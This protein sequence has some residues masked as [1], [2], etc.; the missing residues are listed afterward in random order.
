MGGAY[1]L[2]LQWWTAQHYVALQEGRGVKYRASMS[3]T[4]CY[5]IIYKAEAHIL[6]ICVGLLLTNLSH[7]G[8]AAGTNCHSGDGNETLNIHVSTLQYMR[9]VILYII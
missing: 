9:H 5:P 8:H 4:A 6:N 2:A 7:E 1:E 3:D